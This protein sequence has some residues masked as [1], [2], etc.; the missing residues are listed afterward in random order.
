VQGHQAIRD[1]GHVVGAGRGQEPMP[2]GQ[3]S[4]SLID[5]HRLAGRL[6]QRGVQIDPHAVGVEHGR[7]PLTPE[8]I[9]RR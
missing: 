6:A 4:P 1:R 9:E 5:V 3:P 2:L 7:V 8:R